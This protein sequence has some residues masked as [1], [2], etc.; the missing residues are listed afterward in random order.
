MEQDWTKEYRRRGEVMLRDYA[1]GHH[2]WR[3]VVPWKMPHQVS[4][5]LG[6]LGWKWG[7]EKGLWSFSDEGV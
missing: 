3:Q 6:T 4:K 5:G 2:D 7:K 1:G